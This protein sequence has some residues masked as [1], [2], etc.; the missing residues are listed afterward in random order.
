MF[1]L[2]IKFIGLF[3]VG[4]VPSCHLL[5]CR[6]IFFHFLSLSLFKVKMLTYAVNYLMNLLRPCSLFRKQH[7]SMK[8]LF[9]PFGWK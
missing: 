4:G 8:V 9:H 2:L 3:G 6:I 5:C 1:L 7:S